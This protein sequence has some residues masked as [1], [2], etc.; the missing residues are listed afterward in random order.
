MFKSMCSCVAICVCVIAYAHACMC[1]HMYVHMLMY[2]SCIHM[3]CVFVC[4]A[5]T[6]FTYV[7]CPHICIVCLCSQACVHLSPFTQPLCYPGNP[8]T[9]E[10]GE[11]SPAWNP[12]PLSQINP[13]GLSSSGIRC[14]PVFRSCVTRVGS[15]YSWRMYTHTHPHTHH[16]S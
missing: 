10:R 4:I 15:D 3:C 14:A 1:A 13:R 9:L 6:V 5:C 7:V 2:V 8:S 12:G 11:G 16:G